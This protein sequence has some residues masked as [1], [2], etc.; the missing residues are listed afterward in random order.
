MMTISVVKAL[1]DATSL[2]KIM[3][4]FASGGLQELE[5]FILFDK[6]FFF[7]KLDIFYRK[8]NQFILE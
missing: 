6:M 8:M 5:G 7:L 4:P 2:H 3:T 1:P